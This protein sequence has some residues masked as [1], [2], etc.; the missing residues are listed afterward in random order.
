MRDPLGG[1]S[2]AQSLDRNR[3]MGSLRVPTQQAR[4]VGTGSQAA[5]SAVRGGEYALDGKSDAG[6]GDS[7]K[8]S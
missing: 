3:L 2:D 4:L 1:A 6:N 7:Q 5:L 8:A